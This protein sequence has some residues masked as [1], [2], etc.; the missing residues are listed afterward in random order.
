MAVVAA[1]T[2]PERFPAGR[3]RLTGSYEKRTRPTTMLL[4]GVQRAIVTLRGH[5]A[6]SFTLVAL[7]VG[8]TLCLPRGS[9]FPDV[10]AGAAPGVP[11]F[12]LLRRF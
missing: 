9:C 5:V 4:A 11:C 2:V 3:S 10:E 7:L 12:L 1:A 6:A 8:C